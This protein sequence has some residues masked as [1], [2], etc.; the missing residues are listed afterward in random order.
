MTYLPTYADVRP[1]TQS[2]WAGIK[3]RVRP[4]RSTPAESCLSILTSD[5]TAPSGLYWI[6][7]H[8]AEIGTNGDAGMEVYCLM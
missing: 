7:K 2:V 3:T 8:E 4:T 5:P 1:V 6:L